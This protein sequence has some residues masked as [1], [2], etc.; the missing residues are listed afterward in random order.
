MQAMLVCIYNFPTTRTCARTHA[1]SHK[2]GIKGLVCIF[3]P[4]R[5]K[6]PHVAYFLQCFSN[7]GVFFS[8]TLQ[9]GGFPR[10]FPP[11]L[12]PKNGTLKKRT[13]GTKCLVATTL[14]NPKMV[15]PFWF[16][17]TTERGVQKLGHRQARASTSEVCDETNRPRAAKLRFQCPADWQKRPGPSF[18]SFGRPD[19]ARGTGKARS[20]SSYLE[21]PLPEFRFELSPLF[22]GLDHFGEP[23]GLVTFSGQSTR[24]EAS[25]CAYKQ[26]GSLPKENGDSR[27]SRYTQ[28]SSWTSRC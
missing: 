28:S 11:Q 6:I 21:S 1:R 2:G 9:H 13:P 14:G 20:L 27:H 12:P 26:F 10:S 5:P 22:W 8:G 16:P 7:I 24:S 17:S 25:S 4:Q 23:K 18:E 3:G 15:C 19:P